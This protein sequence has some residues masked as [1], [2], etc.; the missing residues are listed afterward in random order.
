MDCWGLWHIHDVDL[1]ADLARVIAQLSARQARVLVG[2]DGPDAA[3]KTTLAENLTRL[4]YE[5]KTVAQEHSYIPALY[6]H[7]SPDV[8]IYLDASFA[9]IR[10]RRA[11]D[12]DESS[13]AEERARLADAR[14]TCDLYV[15]TDKLNADQVFRRVRRWLEKRE[16]VRG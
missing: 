2:I 8:V 10:K 13:L 9:A 3:G 11:I 1:S 14:Q 16:G 6:R 15:K 5:A 12:W 4:G 7:T